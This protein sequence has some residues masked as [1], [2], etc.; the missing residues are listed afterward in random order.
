ME[1][2]AR[3]TVPRVAFA[4]RPPVVATGP[5]GQRAGLGGCLA[6]EPTVNDELKTPPLA[7][8]LGN[9]DSLPSRPSSTGGIPSVAA[10]EQD[11]VY[12]SPMQQRAH[13]QKHFYYY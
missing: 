4:A 2:G 12:P 5:T 7:S 9:P 1:N 10:Y 6:L 3:S 11:D 13:H 8:A